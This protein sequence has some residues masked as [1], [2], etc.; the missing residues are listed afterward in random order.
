MRKMDWKGTKPKIIQDGGI[1]QK[2]IASG[3]RAILGA[4]YRAT[5]ARPHT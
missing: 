5:E 2:F 3:M 1:V 4:Y